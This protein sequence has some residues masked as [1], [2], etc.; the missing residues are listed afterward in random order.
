MAHLNNA[1]FMIYVRLLTRTIAA[2][3]GFEMKHIF[4]YILLVLVAGAFNVSSVFGASITI[5]STGG[6]G[7]VIQGSALN[8]VAG[9]EMTLGYDSSK[10]S[11]PKVTWG[12]LVSGAI[13]IANTT[14]PGS[15]RIAIINTTPF[16]SSSGAIATIAFAGQ[17][18]SC[19]ITSVSAKLIDEKAAL[20]PVTAAIAA[21]AACSAPVD[22]VL[23]TT[24][25]VPFTQ[26]T[27][28]SVSGNVTTTAAPASTAS[29]ATVKPAATTA[30]TLQAPVSPGSIAI[31]TDSAPRK[32]DK[33]AEPKQVSA[34]PE[35]AEGTEVVNQQVQQQEANKTV[36][37]TEP[38]SIKQ[39]VY[40]GVLDRFR[41]FQGAKTPDN[42][43]GLFSKRVAATIRQEPA[44]IVSDGS[45]KVR[46]VVGLSADKDASTNF[47]LTGANLVSLEN[48]GDSGKWVLDIL[49]Q[50][51]TL[52]AV[53]TVLNSRMI[54]DFPLTVVPPAGIVTGSKTDFEDFLKDSGAKVPKFD[55]N[56]DG[57]HD[58]L[59]D[60][61]YTAHYLMKSAVVAR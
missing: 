15:I 46:V 36:R 41:L 47:A 30:T 38:V 57:R 61:I 55:L 28:D 11:A 60:Y 43:V 20:V 53:V 10:L 59:D 51:N 14:I 17:S 50:A 21:E 58:Y 56:G 32:E 16:A 52:K 7:F 44:V 40:E 49:P 48:E 5:E 45:S 2:L 22:P 31:S 18:A 12:A 23:I 8:S 37:A 25:G 6:G 19:G 13:S 4:R 1:D 42:L 34:P 9:V 3:K 33:P 39:T 26:E 29:T 24:P 27:R 35:S 54:V